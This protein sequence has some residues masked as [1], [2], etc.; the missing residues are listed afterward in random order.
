MIF[1]DYDM[2]ES[3]KEFEQQVELGHFI[4]HE[5]RDLCEPYSL[6]GH[7]IKGEWT[8]FYALKDEAWRIP[9][10]MLLKKIMRKHAWSDALERM[11][12]TLLGYTD[13]QNDEHLEKRRL[14]HAGWQCVT[15]YDA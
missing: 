1:D 6:N 2:W 3:D 7:L 10:F 5:V 15:L 8:R 4:K 13:E 11:E 14:R 9:A 12:G